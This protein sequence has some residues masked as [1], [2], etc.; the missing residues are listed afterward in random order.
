MAGGEAMAADAMIPPQ[1][2]GLAASAIL[3]VVGSLAPQVVARR[4]SPVSHRQRGHGVA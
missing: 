2:V 1:L 3:M 4:G